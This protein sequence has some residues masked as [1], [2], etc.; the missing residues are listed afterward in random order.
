MSVFCAVA[1]ILLWG[2]WG[3]TNKQATNAAHPFNIEWQSSVIG[4]I[5][6][7]GLLPLWGYLSN[8]YAPATHWDKTS[9]M[10]VFCSLVL[11]ILSSLAFLFGLKDSKTGSVFIALT[12]AYPIVTLSIELASGN[13]HISVVQVIGIVLV[14]VGAVLVSL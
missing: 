3:W 4:G 13:A 5:V 12:A 14:S 7:L 11:A 10:W 8:K 6:W 9:M 2:V 1:V